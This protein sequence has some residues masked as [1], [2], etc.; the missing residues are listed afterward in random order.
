MIHTP[1]SGHCITGAQ[2]TSVWRNV[3]RTPHKWVQHHTMHAPVQSNQS[4]PAHGHVL[5]LG[6][7]TVQ[8]LQHML[9]DSSYSKRLY[10]VH[11]WMCSAQGHHRDSR[12]RDTACAHLLHNHH[13]VD[14]IPLAMQHLYECGE[15]SSLPPVDP[16]SDHKQQRV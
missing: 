13:Y 8:R 9:W 1:L 3:N 6:R 7:Q 14:S 16:P 2:A 5:L 10:S 11:L 15:P 4:A 12:C